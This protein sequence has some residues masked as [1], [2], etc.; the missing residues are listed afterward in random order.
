ME[1]DCVWCHRPIN[2]ERAGWA[3]IH[4]LALLH[5]H[6]CAWRPIN[7]TPDTIEATAER[8]ADGVERQFRQG[9]ERG[10]QPAN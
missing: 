10:E 8:I 3:Y 4:S 7:A 2:V 6:S 5:L 9:Q 1:F